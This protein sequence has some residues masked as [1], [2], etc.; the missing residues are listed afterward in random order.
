[1]KRI[2]ITIAIILVVA[3]VLFMIFASPTQLAG[4]VAQTASTA[5]TWN[6]TFGNPLTITGGLTPGPGS[7]G[8]NTGM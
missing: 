7:T 6:G 3:I 1:M 5:G 2:L 8:Q 4:A